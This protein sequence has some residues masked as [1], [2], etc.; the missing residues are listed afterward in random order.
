M[1]RENLDIND[2]KVVESRDYFFG[3]QTE[4]YLDLSIGRDII[5]NPKQNSGSL[6]YFVYPYAEVNGES[7]DFISQEY[8]KYKVNFQEN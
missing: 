1:L 7:I 4:T 2:S 3:S 5:L 8:L 6:N